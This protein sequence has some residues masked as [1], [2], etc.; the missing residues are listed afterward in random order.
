MTNCAL[1]SG[2]VQIAQLTKQ[3][4]M[5]KAELESLDPNSNYKLFVREFGNL[6]NMC[7]DGGDEFNPLKEMK[8]GVVNPYSD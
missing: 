7:K 1:E 4:A 3:A 6:G 5:A 2:N 8:Y